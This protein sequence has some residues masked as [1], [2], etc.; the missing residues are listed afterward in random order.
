MAFAQAEQEWLKR[1]AATNKK[2]PDNYCW[3]VRRLAKFYTDEGK[4]PQAEVLLTEVSNTVDPESP[5]HTD[6]LFDLAQTL[7]E[8][9]KY[10]SADQ[11][12]RR[13]LLIQ[14][15]N[16]EASSLYYEPNSKYKLY[17]DGYAH[18]LSLMKADLS[19]VHKEQ[20]DLYKRIVHSELEYFAEIS[21]GDSGERKNAVDHIVDAKVQLAEFYASSGNKEEARKT[22]GSAIASIFA[23][24]EPDYCRAIKLGKTYSKMLKE[25]RL[26]WESSKIQSDLNNWTQKINSPAKRRGKGQLK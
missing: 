21:S 13:L 3:M 26:D 22:Y 7:V 2:D 14:K 8:E 23:S 25:A 15:R 16:T 1:V 11:T 19:S 20:E 9:K 12:Y 5:T 10:E 6:V 4:F 18:L 17:L 24:P